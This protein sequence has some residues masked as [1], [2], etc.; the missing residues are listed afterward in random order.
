[1]YGTMVTTAIKWRIGAVHLKKLD[2]EKVDIAE[3]IAADPDPGSCAF[4]TPGPGRFFR[5]P[6]A[7]LVSRIPNP[8][9]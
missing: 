7:D 5:I 8:Y 4:L 2:D 9:F 3:L 1:M 6:V